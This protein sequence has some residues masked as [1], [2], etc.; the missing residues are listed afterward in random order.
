[1][2]NRLGIL[3][4]KRTSRLRQQDLPDVAFAITTYLRGIVPVSVGPTTVSG[5]PVIALVSQWF[6]ITVLASDWAKIEPYL[7]NDTF[8][9]S[10]V[11]IPYMNQ[12]YEREALFSPSVVTQDPLYER[13]LDTLKIVFPESYPT[14]DY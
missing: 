5:A 1:M 4:A 3:F 10:V 13:V 9:P 14:S 7:R 2:D 8:N 12:R 11:P 6:N